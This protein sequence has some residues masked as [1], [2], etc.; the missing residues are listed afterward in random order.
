MKDFLKRTEKY[1]SRIG[2]ALS[3]LFNVIVGGRS[4]QTFSARNY[5][6][7]LNGKTN[8][9]WLIDSIFFWEKDHCYRS[10]SYWERISERK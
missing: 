8:L 7:K 5:E 2:T 1:F 4:N 6:R 3:I 9:V 10:W